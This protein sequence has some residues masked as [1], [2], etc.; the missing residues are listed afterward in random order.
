MIFVAQKAIVPSHIISVASGAFLFFNRFEVLD[1]SHWIKRLIRAL[2]SLHRIYIVTGHAAFF[3]EKAKM[4]FVGKFGETAHAGVPGERC[5]VDDTIAV[6]AGIYAMT[7]GALT[8]SIFRCELLQNRGC[9][10]GLILA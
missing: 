7:F 9:K 5:P 4:G 8:L 2:K 10:I 1:E 3:R 6:V